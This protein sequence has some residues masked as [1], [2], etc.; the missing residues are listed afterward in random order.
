[1]AL[2]VTDKAIAVAQLLGRSDLLKDDT[3][4]RARPKKTYTEHELATHMGVAESTIGHWLEPLLLQPE[5]RELVEK[6][7]LAIKVADKIRKKAKTPEEEVELAQEFAKVDVNLKPGEKGA[8]PEREAVALLNKDLS[9]EELIETLKA[10]VIRH[11]H[12]KRKKEDD[13]ADEW[14]PIESVTIDE[15]V[16]TDPSIIALFN[17][18]QIQPAAHAQDILRTWLEINCLN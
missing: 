11:I 1:M 13:E 14:V 16:V 2:L 4:P 3:P 12:R 5:T 17:K 9:K 15:C 8:L 6:G 18:Y 10:I 7:T